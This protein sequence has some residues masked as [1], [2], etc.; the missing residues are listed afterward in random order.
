MDI[1]PSLMHRLPNLKVIHLIR[2]PRGIMNSRV[3]V[4][5]SNWLNLVTEVNDLC[6]SI[7]RNIETAEKVKQKF[8]DRTKLLVYE[9]LSEYP[10]EISRDLFGFVDMDFSPLVQRRLDRLTHN[11]AQ[12]RDCD[13]CTKKA[14]STKTAL[15]WRTEIDFQHALVIEKHCGGVY[16]LVGY[17]R[18]KDEQTLR[19]LSISLH[20]RILP[21]GTL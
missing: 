19:N 7:V 16:D 11:R 14:N 12:A 13:W 1:I 20:N 3:K 4:K 15:M 10:T 6:S 21:V 18:T 9:Q 5:L 17:L 8:P 2:D